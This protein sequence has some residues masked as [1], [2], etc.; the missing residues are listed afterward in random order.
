MDYIEIKKKVYEACQ[1]F[2]NERKEN[3]QR[4]IDNAQEAANEE[5][6]NSAGDKYETGRSMFQMEREK[7]EVQ[8]FQAMKLQE[9][10]HQLDPEKSPAKVEKG[11]LVETEQGLFY[12]AVGAGKLEINGKTV[13]AMD[14]GA[15]LGKAMNGKTVGDDF[16]FRDRKQKIKA[17]H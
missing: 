9:A 11:A 6:K 13:V 16:T 4:T 14:P 7:G 15:P 8:L 17:I 5:S 2:I 12:L 10:L 1:Q 3:A